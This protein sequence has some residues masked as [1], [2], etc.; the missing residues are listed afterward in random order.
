MTVSIRRASDG[1]TTLIRA[2]CDACGWLG[3]VH[4]AWTGNGRILVER[5]ASEHDRP[6]ET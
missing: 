2:A 1:E 5:D 6:H 3:P 4:D